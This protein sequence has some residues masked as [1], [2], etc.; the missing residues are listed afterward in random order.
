MEHS[1]NIERADNLLWLNDSLWRTWWRPG[2]RFAFCVVCTLTIMAAISLLVALVIPYGMYIILAK[3]GGGIG[4]WTIEFRWLYYRSYVFAIFD[5]IPPRLFG[6]VPIFGF[7]VPWTLG[8]GFSFGVPYWFVPLCTG[9]T[10]YYAWRR[11]VWLS[12]Q[13]IHECAHCG[14]DLRAHK[15][16]DKCPECGKVIEPPKAS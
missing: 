2:S 4:G 1:A 13:S 14:Y 8:S 3:T 11:Y 6:D 16:G 5:C 7:F 9:A 12:Y 10:L 15:V